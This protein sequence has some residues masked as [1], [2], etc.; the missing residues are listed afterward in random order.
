LL[1]AAEAWAAN[2]KA[3][4][5]TAAAIAIFFMTYPSAKR[6]FPLSSGMCRYS[7]HFKLNRSHLATLH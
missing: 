3:E 5:A 4:T 1:T 7:V 6:V 2:A